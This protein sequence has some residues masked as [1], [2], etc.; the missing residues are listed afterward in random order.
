MSSAGACPAQGE[1]LMET[2]RAQIVLL[3]RQVAVALILGNK[4]FTSWTTV[5]QAPPL[6]NA[7][8]PV[9]LQIMIIERTKGLPSLVDQKVHIA[10]E[11]Y[12][13]SIRRNTG[14]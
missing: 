11:K 14:G 8:E 13:R 7:G 6:R 2:G 1:S 12:G 9:C 10:G 4:L 3:A 5:G